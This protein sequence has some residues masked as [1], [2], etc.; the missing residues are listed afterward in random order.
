ME[1]TSCAASTNASH[2]FSDAADVF[3]SNRRK[4][5]HRNF[6]LSDETICLRFNRSS[7]RSWRIQLLLL[8][9]V[10]SENAIA[11]AAQPFP[12]SP[13]IKHVRVSLGGRPN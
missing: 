9:V 3:R 5:A 8:V 12:N 2:R 13:E 7:K 6:A 11:E 1:M 10:E 4:T